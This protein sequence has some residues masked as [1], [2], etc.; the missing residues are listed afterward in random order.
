M[1]GPHADIDVSTSVKGIAD[2]LE[3]KAGSGTHEFL[4][5]RGDTLPW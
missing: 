4:D 2:V 3:A 1:G 5:Y